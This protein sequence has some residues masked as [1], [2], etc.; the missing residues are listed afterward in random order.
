MLEISQRDLRETMVM[1]S[2][3]TMGVQIVKLMRLDRLMG[4]QGTMRVQSAM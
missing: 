4:S 2:Q 1:V 3:V